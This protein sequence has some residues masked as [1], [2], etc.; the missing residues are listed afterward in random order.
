[1]SETKLT[2]LAERVLKALR[3]AEDRAGELPAAKSV[4]LRPEDWHALTSL[5][6]ELVAQSA[7]PS[8]EGK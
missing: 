2:D 3:R 6:R 4:K 7:A 5:T 8:S 1:M